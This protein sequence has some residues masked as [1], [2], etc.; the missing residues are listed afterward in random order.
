MCPTVT[1]SGFLEGE[2]LAFQ[3]QIWQ[4]QASQYSKKQDQ[5]LFI[6]KMRANFL[7]DFV[8]FKGDPLVDKI[9]FHSAQCQ[10]SPMYRNIFKLAKDLDLDFKTSLKSV[11]HSTF[12]F[13]PFSSTIET[14]CTEK[15]MKWLLSLEETNSQVFKQLDL[16]KDYN[17]STVHE[18]LHVIYSILIPPGEGDRDE[19]FKF[20]ES[21]VVIHEYPLSL[22]FGEGITDILRSFNL[23]Y[24][25]F[26]P[27]RGGHPG[28]DFNNDLRELFLIFYLSVSR[29]RNWKANI[30]KINFKYQFRSSGFS[31]KFVEITY[32]EWF[33]RNKNLLYPREFKSKELPK[34]LKRLKLK[35]FSL[36]YFE[37]NP[38]V[39]SELFAWRDEVL[40]YSGKFNRC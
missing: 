4:R 28:V 21:M 12:T 24:K 6:Q 27:L 36:K 10:I 2:E 33:K 39:L 17:F 3:M 9:P 14:P 13:N 16:L 30:K 1:A 7:W 25:K 40:P 32:P 29:P 11:S 18:T 35:E 20:M 26:T 19:Y 23:F 31:P 37:D 38:K 22:E 5:A 15:E 34:G 8:K